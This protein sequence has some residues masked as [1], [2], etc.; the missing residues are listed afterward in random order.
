MAQDGTSG[1]VTLSPEQGERVR[2]VVAGGQEEA[3]EELLDGAQRISPDLRHLLDIPDLV[4]IDFAK[5]RRRFTGRNRLK[6]PYAVDYDT[7]RPV[8]LDL[9][10]PADHQGR[11]PHGMVIGMTGSGKTELLKTL[12]TIIV[13]TQPTEMCQIFAGDFKYDVAFPQFKALPHNLGMVSNTDQ[14]KNKAYRFAEVMLGEHKRRSTML[15]EVG[16]KD[17]REWNRRRAGGEDLPAMPALVCFFDE[18]PEMLNEWPDLGEFMARIVKL[19]RGEGYAGLRTPEHF[20]A[21]VVD[22]VEANYQLI[23]DQEPYFIFRPKAK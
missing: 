10:E 6:L 23:S 5:L 16:A 13:M 15:G 19:T 8:T 20:A 4:D 9:R 1:V 11:G 21:A 12:Y 18:F 2:G 14:D 17:A 7:G 22:R 3:L